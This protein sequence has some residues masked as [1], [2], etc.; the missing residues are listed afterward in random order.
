MQTMR[1]MQDIPVHTE[2]VFPYRILAITDPNFGEV[3]QDLKIYGFA[4]M[5]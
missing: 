5:Y 1:A 2:T 3:Q 4:Y